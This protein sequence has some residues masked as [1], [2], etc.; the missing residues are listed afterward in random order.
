MND[1]LKSIRFWER[2]IPLIQQ[3]IKTETRRP[4]TQACAP[5]RGSEW[6][7]CDCYDIDPSDTPCVVCGARWGLSPHGDA[8][9]VLLVRHGGLH[10]KPWDD[11]YKPRNL[12]WSNN[13]YVWCY[14][15]EVLK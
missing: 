4:V 9:N 12:A 10:I 2:F 13:P 11:I 8:G 6:Q 1:K 7:E 15:F 5:R 3:G 14:S